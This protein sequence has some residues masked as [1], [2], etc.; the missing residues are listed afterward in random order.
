MATIHEKIAGDVAGNREWWLECGACGDKRTI[1]KV[2]FARY[3][4]QGWPECCGYTVTLSR[5]EA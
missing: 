1:T 2:Q 4:A 3:L 5:S